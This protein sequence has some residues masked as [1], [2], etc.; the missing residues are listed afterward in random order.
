MLNFE[1]FSPRNLFV[2]AV[3]SLIAFAGYNYFH[4]KIGGSANGNATS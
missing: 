1:L 4:K 3:I 2:I